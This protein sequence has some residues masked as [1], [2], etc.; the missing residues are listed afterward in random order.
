MK[1]RGSGSVFGSME[2]ILWL[3]IV[4]GAIGGSLATNLLLNLPQVVHVAT[5]ELYE[6]VEDVVIERRASITRLYPLLIQRIEYI[7]EYGCATYTAEFFETREIEHERF[8]IIPDARL[9][10][11]FCGM[12]TV[13][14]GFDLEDLEINVRAVE[15][16][17]STQTIAIE[18][19]LGPPRILSTQIDHGTMTCDVD[20]SWTGSEFAREGIMCLN[21]TLLSDASNGL[22]ERAIYAGILERAGE[23]VT[24]NIE[25]LVEAM[26]Y[27]AQVVVNTR[28][29][30]KTPEVEQMQVSP[31]ARGIDLMNPLD[32][33]IHGELE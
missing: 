9:R 6:V 24:Q 16:S 31:D 22:I 27:E 2:R 10:L 30:T 5:I 8:L 13:E 7:A 3:A 20:D 12:G 26:G 4:I 23:N 25:D 33:E 11:T 14:A 28:G 17:D 1:R 32:L 21:R 18:V 19:M 29:I 15:G